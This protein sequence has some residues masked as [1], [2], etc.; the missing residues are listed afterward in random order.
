MTHKLKVDFP[1]KKRKK[2]KTNNINTKQAIEAWEEEGSKTQQE[3]ER[4]LKNGSLL[5]KKGTSEVV[6][7]TGFSILKHK[8]IA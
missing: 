8:I 1:E 5:I 2:N 4:R 6:L 3:R 7:K